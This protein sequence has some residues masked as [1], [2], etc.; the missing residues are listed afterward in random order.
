MPYIIISISVIVL[1]LIILGIIFIIKNKEIKLLNYKLG[2]ADTKIINSLETL[3]Q[4][5]TKIKDKI[6]DKELYKDLNDTKKE[7]YHE[8]NDL[9]NIL[10]TE[11]QNYIIEKRNLNPDDELKELLKTLEYETFSALSYKDYYNKICTTYNKMIKKIP[12]NLKH[13]KEKKPYNN[14]TNIELEILSK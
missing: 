11:L 9:E 4:I 14:N 12:L 8:L 13:L 10:Y 2:K 6:N 5:Y 1:T 7:N 3:E